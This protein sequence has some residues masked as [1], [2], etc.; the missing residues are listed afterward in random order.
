[1]IHTLFLHQIVGQ[2]VEVLQA[3]AQLSGTVPIPQVC[4]Q[5]AQVAL[6]LV[7]T[8]LP[9]LEDVGFVG[10]GCWRISTARS[11]LI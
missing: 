3:I 1:M 8:R 9:L 4:N 7:S 10:L 11:R 6:E 5:P 2:G